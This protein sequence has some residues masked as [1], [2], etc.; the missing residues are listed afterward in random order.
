MKPRRYLPL[1]ADVISIVAAVVA[2]V[3]TLLRH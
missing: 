1:A 2:L 3:T